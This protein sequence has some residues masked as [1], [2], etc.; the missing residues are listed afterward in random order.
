[1]YSEIEF[2][3]DPVLAQHEAEARGLTLVELAYS[4]DTVESPAQK[5][6]RILV[7]QTPSLNDHN[8]QPVLSN[9]TDVATPENV[10]A[11]NTATV[12]DFSS[13]LADKLMECREG[14]L[15]AA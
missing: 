1:M 14:G 10:I 4:S 5:P 11:G 3:H 6:E 8:Q 9:E 2:Q 13:R 12:I 15:R 7:D